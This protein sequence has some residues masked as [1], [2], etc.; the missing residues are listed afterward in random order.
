MPISCDA[1]PIVEQHTASEATGNPEEPG[2]HVQVRDRD[3][4]EGGSDHDAMAGAAVM[5]VHHDKHGYN[6]LTPATECVGVPGM[7]AF[8][9]EGR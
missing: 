6:I 3:G 5:H 7:V 9:M 4:E 8:A 1:D 2:A